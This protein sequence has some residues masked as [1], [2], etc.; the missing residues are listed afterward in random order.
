MIFEASTADELAEKAVAR[1]KSRVDGLEPLEGRQDEPH[2]FIA[3]DVVADAVDQL[4]HRPGSGVRAGPEAA[5]QVG[6]AVGRA[7]GEKVHIYHGQAILS[8]I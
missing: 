6:K 3:A 7:V 2:F 5:A 8:V 1:N 4:Y